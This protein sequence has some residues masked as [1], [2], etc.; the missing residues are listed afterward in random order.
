MTR[1]EPGWAGFGDF[2]CSERENYCVIHCGGALQLKITPN[3]LRKFYFVLAPA[4]AHAKCM[5]I[6]RT[7]TK[8]PA[9]AGFGVTF[10]CSEREN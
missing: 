7:K 9:E 1:I 3:F 5:A 4:S 8:N 2:L 6:A 10:H